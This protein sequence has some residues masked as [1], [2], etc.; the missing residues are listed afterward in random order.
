MGAS[1]T[2]THVTRWKLSLAEREEDS[3]CALSGEPPGISD[4]PE[5]PLV[6]KDRV[7]LGK[8]LPSPVLGPKH[9]AAEGALVGQA[10]QA[11]SWI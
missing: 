2:P 6:T 3:S 5:G 9:S 8:P 11:C 4:L 7:C 1:P 10:S